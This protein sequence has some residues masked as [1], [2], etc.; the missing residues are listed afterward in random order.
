MAVFASAV[1]TSDLFAQQTNLPLNRQLY[2]N[3][4]R[5]LNKKDV[6]F[7]TAMKPWL[8]GEIAEFV[9]YDSL[10]HAELKTDE[11]IAKRRHPRTWEKMIKSHFL[12]VKKEDYFLAADALFDLQLGLD[13]ASGSRVSVNT[14]GA[15]LMGHLGKNFS[16]RTGFY[17][18]QLLPANYI[19]QYILADTIVPGQGG[20]RNFKGTGVDVT[21]AFGYISWQMNKFFHVQAGHGKHFIGNGYR[22]LLLSDN[23]FDY[24]F[25]RI[26]TSVWNIKYTNIYTQFIDLKNR[27][28]ELERLLQKY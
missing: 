18:T 26:E 9:N 2:D 20:G 10:L 7:H 21:S 25:I 8:E 17:E 27:S 22:S 23:S 12:K 1:F 28:I 16:F 4:E 13:L 19:K 5:H 11:F 24:P 6:P 14:R 15:R 3:Y